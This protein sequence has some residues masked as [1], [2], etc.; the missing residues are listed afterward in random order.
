MSIS[1][2]D[3]DSQS[4]V[5]VRQM[6]DG[7]FAEHNVASSSNF[8]MSSCKWNPSSPPIHLDKHQLQNVQY[9]GLLLSSDLSWSHHIE[10]TCMYQG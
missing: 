7:L 9:L 10:A 8:G 4:Q 2:L 1:L 3:M 6:I 5:S